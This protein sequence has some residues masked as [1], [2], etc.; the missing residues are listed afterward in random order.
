M[1]T[2]EHASGFGL[3]L[4]DGWDVQLD[5]RAGV[6]LIAIEPV[7]DQRPVAMNHVVTVDDLPA[8]MDFRSWQLGSDVLLAEGLAGYKLIDLDRHEVDCH[9]AVRRVAVHESPGWPV[10]M[11]QLA[12]LASGRGYTLTTTVSTLD[13]PG[14]LEQ[15]DAVAGSLT[16]TGVSA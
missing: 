15:I 3:T 2:L 6:A 11:L 1:T 9:E 14:S 8:G 16:V 10:T 7:S 12:V 4:P 13:L 5:P